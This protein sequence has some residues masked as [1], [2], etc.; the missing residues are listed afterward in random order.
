GAIDV[1]FVM[2]VVI[3][4]L[5][6]VLGSA[7][8]AWSTPGAPPKMAPGPGERLETGEIL[9]LVREAVNKRL[10]SGFSCDVV[11]DDI[12]GLTDLFDERFEVETH[13]AIVMRATL[14]EL[15]AGTL[16]V[17]GPRG[18]GKTTLIRA[19]TSG[20]LSGWDSPTL[21]ITVPA[22]VRYDARDFVPFLLS[23]LCMA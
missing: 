18:A 11:L 3:L 9:P 13:S 6:G 10:G 23:R 16:G 19:A 17:F 20:R 8:A 4:M 14:G 12:G 7:F 21:G 15:R 22:P 5:V 2:L 1:P